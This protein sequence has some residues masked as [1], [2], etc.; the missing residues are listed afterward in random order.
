M[1]S[2]SSIGSAVAV[3][4]GGS[5]PCGPRDGLGGD[6]MVATSCAPDTAGDR[7]GGIGKDAADTAAK[8]R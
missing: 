7:V 6:G 4:V 8:A 5:K 3:R 1:T 2:S